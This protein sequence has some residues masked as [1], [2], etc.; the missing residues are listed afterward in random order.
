MKDHSA[1][2][3]GVIILLVFAAFL[4]FNIWSGLEEKIN[5]IEAS[6]VSVEEIVSLDAIFF[7]DQI[8][9]KGNT[10][11]VEYLVANGEK[12]S[13][14][15]AVCIYFK[16]DEA[17]ANYRKL[18]EIK[19]EIEAIEAVYAMISSGTESI[20][21]DALV[22]TYLNDIVA[23]A[24]SGKLAQLQETYRSLEQV[25]IAR[26][27]GLYSKDIFTEKLSSLKKQQAEYESLVDLY[28]ETVKA[29]V[30]GYFFSE[31]DGYESSFSTD[32]LQDVSVMFG[33]RGE[34]RDVSDENIVGTLVTSFFWY[35]AAEID[36]DMLFDLRGRGNIDVSFP[37]LLAKTA[38]FTVE[39]ISKYADGKYYIVLK[40]TLMLPE[41]LS[42]RFQPMDVVLNTYTGIKVPVQALHQKDGKW[43]VFCLEGAS[44]RFK[45][46]EIIYQTD[47][48]YLLKMAD[49]ASGGLYLYD[50]IIISGKDF[51]VK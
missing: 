3:A 36:E 29:P 24:D 27:A 50:K 47:T 9:I 43:G 44:A 16:S 49:S 7:R 22:Y 25:I 28:S 12:V 48:F 35:L 42:S 2:G 13:A 51:R 15:Q 21:L 41:Y 17:R 26:D 37:E 4:I 11:N 19:D 5:Y 20:K 34:S 8:V 32:C 30:S 39:S 1:R 18:T 10:D 46:V 6:S 14:N 45:P 38:N 23:N 33:D 40:S 31:T